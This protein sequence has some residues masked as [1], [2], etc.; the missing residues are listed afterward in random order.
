ME[1]LGLLLKSFG[2]LTL[3]YVVYKLILQKNT[4]FTAH[5][6]FL[7]SGLISAIVIPFITFTKKVTIVLPS[8]PTNLIPFNTFLDSS[9][10][11]PVIALSNPAINWWEL[12]M[13]IYGLG[14][15]IMT[16]KVL[17]QLLSLYKLINSA[18]IVHKNRYSYIELDED[19]APFSFFSYIIYNPSTHTQE[20]LKMILAHEQIHASEFHSLDVLIAQILVIL[21]WFNPIVWYYKH[22]LEQNLEYIADQKAIEQINNPIHYQRA[23]VKV[24]SPSYEPAL[25]NQFYQS[26][27]KKRIIMLNTPKSHKRNLWKLGIV[28]PLLA[29][30]MYSFNVKEITEYVEEDTA[31]AKE[32]SASHTI[33]N[34]IPQDLEIETENSDNQLEQSNNMETLDDDDHSNAVNK[35]LTSSSSKPLSILN[36]KSEKDNKSIKE[37]SMRTA[38]LQENYRFKITKKTTI[39]ELVTLKKMLKEKHNATLKYGNIDYN[40]AGEMTSIRL[41]FKDANGNIKNYNTQSN[42]PLADIYIYRDA[43]GNTGMGNI[44]SREEATERFDELREQMQERRDAMMDNRDSLRASMEDRRDEMRTKMEERRENM[45]LRGDVLR[46]KSDSLRKNMKINRD[47]LRLNRFSQKDSLKNWKSNYKDSIRIIQGKASSNL[48]KSGYLKLDNETYY[49][50]Y[51]SD[52]TIGYYNR[53]GTE[54]TQR[55]PLYSKLLNISSTS[56]TN[57]GKEDVRNT[58]L[59]LLRSQSS[60]NKEEPLLLLNGTVISNAAMKQLDPNTIKNVSV[61]KGQSAISL[62]GKKGKNGVIV[63]ETKK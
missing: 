42:S 2:V 54:I 17:L 48:Q 19:I 10:A 37:S 30:F 50:A 22:T 8:Q 24:S 23:L 46:K 3:F 32:N 57:A 58:A 9:K 55:D 20:E 11:T 31:F 38:V 36:K 15:L 7:I 14:I 60:V 33:K 28:L 44:A 41:S 6:Y 49:Y 4:L 35:V 1:L 56:L 25:T 26:F 39:E 53:W 27:I 62:Y 40:E 59:T 51:K 16:I 18:T 29:I 61:L 21:H 12:L 45:N 47:S 34:N 63:I 5:R 13:V 52:G 43:D